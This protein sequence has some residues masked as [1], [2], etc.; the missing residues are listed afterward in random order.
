[1]EMEYE[2]LKCVAV[3]KCCELRILLLYTRLNPVYSR[4]E[5]VAEHQN[6]RDHSF[7]MDYWE[8]GSHARGLYSTQDTSRIR[9]A[10]E[11]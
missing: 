7:S 9:I 2:S 3:R 6:T 5:D 10:K 1:M 8:R 11:K 4:C